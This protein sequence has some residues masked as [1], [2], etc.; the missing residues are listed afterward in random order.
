MKTVALDV[1]RKRT[2]MTVALETGKIVREQIVETKAEVLRREIANIPGPKRVVL[3]NGGWAGWIFDALKDV[4]EEVLVCD[5]T[6]NA[7]IA[8]AENSDDRRDAQRL[9]M[10]SHANLLHAVFI[11][12]E[13]FRTLRSMVN[14]ESRLTELL[15]GA[16]LRLKSFC[17]RH[18]VEYQGV[19]IYRRSDRTDVLN[20]FPQDARFQ[21]SSLFRLLD[22]MRQERL[23]VRRELRRLSA[24]IPAIG[25]MES[26]PGIGSVVARLLAAWIVDPWRFK[27][28]NGLSAYGGLGLKRD[29]SNW[30]M[31]RGYA[32]RRGQR[33][34]KR[35][36]FLAA[37]AAIRGDN[38]FARRYQARR[39]AGWDDRKAIRDIARKLLF[40][41]CQVWK[42]KQEY[43][44]GRINIPQASAASPA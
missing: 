13:P 29:T 36:L 22:G 44:D 11:P 34:I 37:R 33:E 32:S 4:A 7:L 10:L 20:R 17:R 21:L 26:V 16:K 40:T 24:R 1:H 18:E 39:A 5:P 27:S 28:R 31:R 42:T 12:P 30:E 2:Q 8:Q 15:I 43:D 41:A 23:A 14:H 38:A 9:A 3:E 19:T 35:V 6:R 25:L